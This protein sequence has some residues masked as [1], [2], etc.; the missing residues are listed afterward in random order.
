[1]WNR[2]SH[3]T[4]SIISTV[5]SASVLTLP[6]FIYPQATKLLLLHAKLLMHLP[7]MVGTWAPTLGVSTCHMGAYPW[8]ER[9]PEIL[10]RYH[11]TWCRVAQ[12]IQLC[13]P[14]AFNTCCLHTV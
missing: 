14:H 4:L 12:A 3:S 9:L 6:N 11:H 8:S 7:L 5:K 13:A 10:L 1:M 2:L